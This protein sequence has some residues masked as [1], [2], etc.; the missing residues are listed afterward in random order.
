MEWSLGRCRR[1]I[2]HIIVH[3]IWH[4]LTICTCAITVLAVLAAKME[5]GNYEVT[6]LKL[7]TLA[8]VYM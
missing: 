2:C 3:Y 6:K 4:L 1:S 7:L 5:Q 8:E